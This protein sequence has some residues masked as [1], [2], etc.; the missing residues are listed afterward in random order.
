MFIKLFNILL[1]LY[2]YICL[3]VSIYFYNIY[4]NV[5]KY[6]YLKNK[7]LFNFIYTYIKQWNSSLWKLNILFLLHYI[8]LLFI[9]YIIYMYVLIF[10]YLYYIVILNLII[11]ILLNHNYIINKLLN[12]FIYFIILYYT[13]ISQIYLLNFKQLKIQSNFYKNDYIISKFIFIYYNVFFN[14][15]FIF[16][17]YTKLKNYIYFD[18]AI[19]KIIIK[20]KFKNFKIKLQSISIF[21]I[22]FVKFYVPLFYKFQ[23]YMFWKKDNR[24][25]IRIFIK[26][27]YYRIKWNLIY[28]KKK[29]IIKLKETYNLFLYYITFYIFNP[30]FN[31][32]LKNNANNIFFNFYLSLKYAKSFCVWIKYKITKKQWKK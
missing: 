8:L 15:Y 16:F 31:F 1:L 2:N 3:F 19:K 20:R 13:F 29:T 17:C 22:L 7:K 21:D 28:I 30:Y 26:S 9:F 11:Y 14:Y 10:F 12:K 27:S 6:S 24:K 25:K 18:I 4:Y 32:L 5:Y 23:K